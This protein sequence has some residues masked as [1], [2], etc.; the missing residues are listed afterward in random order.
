MGVEFE[1]QGL[2]VDELAK[3]AADVLGGTLA[4][5]SSAEFTVG[6]EGQGDYR[7]EV[8]YALLKDAARQEPGEKGSI[9]R[10]VE[11]LRLEA[12]TAASVALVPC[13]V[14]TPPLEMAVLH[15][16]LDA[17]TT[18]IRDAGGKGTRESPLYAF[19]VHFNVE[20]PA[21]DPKTVVAYAKAFVCLF[22]WLVHEGEVDFMRRVTPYI[23]RFPGALELALTQPDYWPDWDTFVV[24]YLRASPTR[25]RALDMLP[26]LAEVNPAAVE[27][28]VDDDR[29]KARPTFHYR[30]AN[31]L[32]DE[33]GWSISEPWGRWLEIERLANDTDLLNSVCEEFVADRDRVLHRIDGGWRDRVGQLIAR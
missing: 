16:P 11:E 33:P 10:K 12:L 13:E 25:N 23:N 30:L 9:A 3:I 15:E 19:G 29:V 28:V 7:I 2:G 27:L 21:M 4:P 20:P 8:D 26:M 17:L 32:I 24:D 22:D 1:L 31:C 14:V 6:V 5:V 18:A